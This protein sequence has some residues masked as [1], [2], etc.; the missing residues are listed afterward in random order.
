MTTRNLQ[1]NIIEAPD[2]R[3]GP[4][5][6]G[7]RKPGYDPEESYVKPPPEDP[8][9]TYVKPPPED[10]E[11]TYVKPPPEDPEET[12]V[13][14][15]PEDPWNHPPGPQL[16]Y[17]PRGAWVAARY[18]PSAAPAA[19]PCR[20]SPCCE[21]KGRTPERPCI[22]PGDYS[23][24]LIVRLSRGVG[25][26]EV[27][28]L[29]E[30]AALP[31]YAALRKVLTL[32]LG[33]EEV[34]EEPAPQAE[35][36]ERGEEG[37]GHLRRW[38]GR[39]D[40]R[41]EEDD[42]GDGP[43]GPEETPWPPE[44]E[45]VLV[46]R[47][48]VLIPGMSRV[49]T[50]NAIDCLEADAAR[51]SFR[52]RHGLARYWRVDLRPYPELVA[53]VLDRFNDLAEVD[54]AYRELR[55]F[56]TSVDD[57]QGYF[58]PAPVG[59][60]TRWLTSHLE[61]ARKTLKKEELPDLGLVDLEQGWIVEHLD[62]AGSL[63]RADVLVHGE[64]READEGGAG[65]HGTA[66][67][68]QLAAAGLGELGVRGSVADLARFF[69]ASHYRKKLEKPTRENPFPGTNGH[70]ASAIV[71]CLVGNPPPLGSGDVLLLEVQRGRLPTETDEAD[72]DAIRLATALGVVVVEAAGNGN[73]DL[74]R[75][76]D[77]QTDRTLQRGAPGFADSG[78]I[79]V[80]AAFS[81]L[82]HER[83]PFSNYGSRVDCYGW[84]EGVTTC[85]YGDLHDGG[86]DSKQYYTN[87][88]NGTSS[89]APIIAGAAALVQY[90]HKLRTEGSLT[91]LALRA[92]LS[93]RATGTP[94]GPNVGGHIGVMPD[95]DAVI[96]DALQLVPDVY[97]RKGPCDDGSH[98][99]PGDAISSCPDVLVFEKEPKSPLTE[100]TRSA[101]HP[102]PG[103][104]PATGGTVYVRLRN[105]GL[106][107]GD[108]Q[109]HLY[110]SPAAT[111]VAPDAWSHFASTALPGLPP[112]DTFR[113]AKAAVWQPAGFGVQGPPWPPGTIEAYSFL[114]VFDRE[115]DPLPDPVRALPPGVPY[116]DWRRYREFLRGPGVA[117]RN[118]HPVA[119]G[120]GA[121]LAFFLA[122]T[123]D[124]TRE[125]DFEVIQRLPEGASVKL[126]VSA[127]WAARLHQRQ[128][129][130]GIDEDGSLVL[131]SRRSVRFGRVRLSRE[132]RSPAWFEVRTSSTPLAEGHSLALRQ[133]WRGEEVGRVTWYVTDGVP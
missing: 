58:D 82:P 124:R 85:G 101:Y 74:D 105:R 2:V 71:N 64:N 35:R 30:L 88:F 3:R 1:I 95:L 107:P 84:G 44:P 39:K 111:L 37:G 13:K 87:T 97:A 18:L 26:L 36:R 9:E 117:W 131:P 19:P 68:G 31:R 114:A 10:P 15:P 49:A 52:P 76:G 72:F 89:A 25:P 67:L 24:F 61:N 106:A 41:P 11:E 60:G 20:C 22:T 130:L 132:V 21:E 94:Q 118:V 4:G 12:Y 86:G 75:C 129:A 14:P 69:L 8:E 78:A 70:V 53:E 98:P 55:A 125:F 102:S 63:H 29:W 116:F 126:H 120:T 110:A 32:P 112:G 113:V 73:H 34:P 47:P 16:G 27:E 92:L 83:A 80:G 50:V 43:A 77:P 91:P 108:V 62:L 127:A 23:G 45:D 6:G 65:N 48:L 66:V 104:T 7:V 122:G 46:S 40:E 96:R 123:P 133:L 109:V 17:G 115:G 103:E 42:D 128:P 93:S 33:D 119:P 59:I 81:E 56:N 99:G 100:S 28:S 79:V 121:S 57:D 90:L 38:L 5:V 51:T 54:L